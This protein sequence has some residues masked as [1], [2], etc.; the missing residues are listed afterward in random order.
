MKKP[1]VVVAAILLTIAAALIVAMLKPATPALVFEG[2]VD[3]PDPPARG[4]SE[5]EGPPKDAAPKDPISDLPAAKSEA[6]LDTRETENIEKLKSLKGLIEARSLTAEHLSEVLTS[7]EGFW[8][9][10]AYLQAAANMKFPEEA[11]AFALQETL[12]FLERTGIPTSDDDPMKREAYFKAIALLSALNA[13]GVYDTQL[14]EIYESTLNPDFLKSISDKAYIGEKLDSL[15]DKKAT[16]II[17]ESQNGDLVET[18]R[19]LAQRA[20]AE[21]PSLEKY[22][23]Q[24]SPGEAWTIEDSDDRKTKLMKLNGISA[25]RSPGKVAFILAEWRDGYYRRLNA[26]S[27]PE[28]HAALA[29][30]TYELAYALWTESDAASRIK[31]ENE[32]HAI[33][34]TD[35]KPTARP[36]KQV[37]A[38]VD[39]A[40]AYVDTCVSNMLPRLCHEELHAPQSFARRLATDYLASLLTRADVA[41]AL[42]SAKS[43]VEM[44]AK[45]R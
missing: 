24:Y 7:S 11:A 32:L 13:H 18:A 35:F 31:A 21:R 3:H 1:T 4:G 38:L 12:N 5:H 19:R 20:P 45:H 39:L 10:A 42:G 23:A 44:A 16:E 17:R 15:D 29:N 41:Q 40:V 6:D 8:L 27:S 22:I 34:S 25:S 2:K 30:P 37:V 26:T 14:K 36:S 28:Q 9:K 43:F 33:F